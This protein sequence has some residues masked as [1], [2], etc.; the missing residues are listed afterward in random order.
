MTCSTNLSVEA[1]KELKKADLL[2]S[3]YSIEEADEIIALAEDAVEAATKVKTFTQLFD[4]LKEA[5]QSGWTQTWEY[6]IG[7]FEEAKELLTSISDFFGGI[8]DA[9]SEARNQIV[10]GWK[11]LGGRDELIASFW[12]IV[13]T[14]QNIANVIRGEFQKFFPPKTSEQL[15]SMTQKFREFTEKLKSFTENSETMEKFRR[16]VTGVAAAFDLVKKGVSWVWNGFKKL[17]GVTGSAASG[18]LDVAAGIGDFFVNA[19]NSIGDSKILQSLLASLGEA[20]TAVKNL[21][22][23]A[24]TKVSSV[25]GSLWAK[26]K[27]SDIL[28]K[29]GVRMSE[30]IG[31][32]PA[33]IQKIQAW[34]KAIID[35]VKNSETLKKAWNN[36][37][38]FFSSTFEKISDFTGKI[39][40]AIREFFS[41]D[42]SDKEG[43]W[44]KL[45][46]RFSAGFSAFS[47]W[48]D[49]AKA[50]LLEA[51]AKIKGV[52]ATF[53]TQ[54]I[55]NFFNE[56]GGKTTNVVS[57][58]AGVDWAKIINTVVGA[59]AAIKFASFL[60]SF[61]KI[62]KGFK[63]IGKGLKNIGE[64]LKDVAEDGI[65]ITKQNKDSI[66]TT[67][68]KIAAS[69]GILVASMLVLSKM[70]TGDILKSLL[71]IGALGAELA[72]MHHA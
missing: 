23:K 30:F 51:W 12:N 63:S 32:I 9:S 54:T 33:F 53:F 21:F 22:S 10:S 6:I 46:A 58:I 36:V 11:D 19:R 29:I 25:F 44:E 64:S 45:K 38:G 47:G 3:G 24:F 59:F 1:V 27:E 13:Y 49:E 52:F 60:G 56:L 43:F 26:V 16:I 15:Y 18:L 5:A 7:D 28:T 4:T 20:A 48:F 62:G 37:K 65:R 35:Y 2:A 41:A 61:S 14:I 55:P 57:A 39:K 68:L 70:D 31:K 17:L 72:I 8:I 67:L 50:K 34:G 69:I 71:V 42:T 40:E 66:G